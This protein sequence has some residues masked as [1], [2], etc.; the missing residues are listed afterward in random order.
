[1][2]TSHI[3][4]PVQGERK[5]QTFQLLFFNSQACIKKKSSLTISV[6]QVAAHGTTENLSLSQLQQTQCDFRLRE[7]GVLM[8]TWGRRNHSLLKALLFLTQETIIKRDSLF[9]FVS[10]FCSPSA[11]SVSYSPYQI[12]LH[13]HIFLLE[14]TAHVIEK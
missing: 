9:Y 14:S 5:G 3:L 8:Q 6:F 10:L 13:Q 7:A 11:A 2:H 1:M 12:S 4:S